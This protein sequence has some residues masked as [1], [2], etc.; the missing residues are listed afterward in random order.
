MNKPALARP[1]WLLPTGR[2]NP[3]WWIGIAGVLF[4]IDYVTAL[5]SLLPALYVIPVTMAAWYSGRRPA[6]ALAIGIPLTHVAFVVARGTPLE[7][8]AQFV[9][10]S[11]I[12]GAVILVMAT[13]THLF[14]L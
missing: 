6:L 2:L 11:I 1:W 13:A 12:R 7:P 4:G 9:A 14:L 10:M 3:L 8:L 5:Y